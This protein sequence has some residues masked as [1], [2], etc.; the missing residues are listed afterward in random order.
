MFS[1]AINRVQGQSR[2]LALIKIS[3]CLRSTLQKTDENGLQTLCG[4]ANTS[5]MYDNLSSSGNHCEK[6]R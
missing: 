2:S 1:R 5:A 3:Y 6:E 4:I